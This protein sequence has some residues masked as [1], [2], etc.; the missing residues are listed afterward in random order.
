MVEYIGLYTLSIRSFFFKENSSQPTTRL[1]STD[2][3]TSI[4]QGNDDWITEEKKLKALEYKYYNS[5]PGWSLI[6]VRV[7]NNPLSDIVSKANYSTVTVS[8]AFRRNHQYYTLTLIV[9]IVVL[10]LLT[11][12]GL[13]MPGSLVKQSL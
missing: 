2:W 12:I 7:T 6:G 13:I 3:K 5:N 9:P 4:L 11:P 10:T 1:N 8:L